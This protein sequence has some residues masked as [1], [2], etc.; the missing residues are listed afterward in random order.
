ME[1]APNGKIEDLYGY[2]GYDASI[3]QYPWYA[4]I[5]G[6]VGIQMV[7]PCGGTIISPRFVMTEAFCGI[8]PTSYHLYF[9]DTNFP[10]NSA[11][12][13]S[14]AFIAHPLFNN[15]S[16]LSNN[17]ALIQLPSAIFFG[18]SV[19][20]IKLPWEDVDVTSLHTF[21]VGARLNG[22]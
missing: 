14:N 15:P 9:G 6:Y 13:I 3:G 1:L 5:E 21:F 11:P 8:A 22:K 4:H 10:H 7:K 18:L 12:V 20:A 16:W 17:I 2:G 19:Q